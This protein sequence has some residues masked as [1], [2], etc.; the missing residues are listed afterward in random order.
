[1]PEVTHPDDVVVTLQSLRQLTTGEEKGCQIEKRYIHKSGRPV[2][3][4]LTV[5][6]IPRA[7]HLQS[8]LSVGV[9]QD[10]GERKAAEDPA[11]KRDPV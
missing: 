2:W 11:T 3:V 4:L 10:I 6:L 7:D 5:T 1:M 9:V 8:D